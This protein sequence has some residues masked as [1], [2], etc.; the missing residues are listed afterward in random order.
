MASRRQ[1]VHALVSRSGN[2][3]KRHQ[4]VRGAGTTQFPV[5]GELIS[6]QVDSS[7]RIKLWQG[8]KHSAEFR[9][10]SRLTGVEEL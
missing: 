2:R 5:N 10:I 7:V 3:H 1:Q 4:I 6:L 8:S 9:E